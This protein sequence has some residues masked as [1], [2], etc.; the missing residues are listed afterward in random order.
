MPS[1]RLQD[2]LTGEQREAGFYL[3]DDEDF[4]FLYDKEGKLLAVFSS[5]GATVESIREETERLIGKVV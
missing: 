4:V 3:A 1:G 2:T 5:H